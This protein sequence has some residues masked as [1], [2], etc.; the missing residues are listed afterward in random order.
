MGLTSGN[1]DDAAILTAWTPPQ[2][3]AAS[4]RIDLFDKLSSRVRAQAIAAAGEALRQ[5]DRLVP[6]RRH[7]QMI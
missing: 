4:A 7:P 3:E 5:G 1:Y 6:W 2:A